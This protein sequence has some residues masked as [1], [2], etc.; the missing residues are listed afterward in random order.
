MPEPAG[1]VPGEGHGAASP[2]DA[3]EGRSTARGG[4]GRGPGE[5]GRSATAGTPRRATRRG[6][7]RGGE[8][9]AARDGG[10]GAVRTGARRRRGRDGRRRRGRAVLLGALGL[11]LAA[12]APTLAELAGDPGRDDTAA[13]FVREAPG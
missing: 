13:D 7:A 5:G 11:L 1:P 6:A 9:D 8:A 12:G 3:R 10:A 4:S 2:S